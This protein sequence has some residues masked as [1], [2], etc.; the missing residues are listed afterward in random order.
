M[1]DKVSLQKCVV[2]SVCF[3]GTHSLPP[4]CPGSFSGSL[5]HTHLNR[6]GKWGSGL[7]AHSMPWECYYSLS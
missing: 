7:W 2:V 5:V 1:G 3:S 6:E 4:P